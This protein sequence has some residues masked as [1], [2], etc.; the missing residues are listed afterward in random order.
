MRAKLQCG[1][2]W[3]EIFIK[4]PYL[5]L[6]PR[7]PPGTRPRSPHSQHSSEGVALRPR[8][9]AAGG[10]ARTL[11]GPV[12]DRRFSPSLPVPPP[13]GRPAAEATWGSHT[14]P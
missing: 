13:A 1:S 5:M 4:P 14:G 9:R 7:Q 8:R 11:A 3:S 12:Q 6:T 10:E 2:K